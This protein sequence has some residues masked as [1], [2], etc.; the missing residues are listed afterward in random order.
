MRKCGACT[1]A[2]CRHQKSHSSSA[3]PPRR[4]AA[5]AV[6]CR[7]GANGVPVQLSLEALVEGALVQLY[8]LVGAPAFQVDGD[9]VTVDQRCVRWA[10]PPF[11]CWLLPPSRPVLPSP[12][13]TCPPRVTC[14]PPRDEAKLRAALVLV[15]THDGKPLRLQLD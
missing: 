7:L 1:A 8:G 13:V 9:V 14:P 3:G 15:S 10:L 2:H 11:P 12:P 5:A 4:A 6:A